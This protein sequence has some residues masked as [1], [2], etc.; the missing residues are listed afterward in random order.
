MARWADLEREAPEVA[1]PGR[2]L[3]YQHG[4]G[5]AYLATNRKDGGL[6]I[7]PFC[8][9]V[10]NGGIYGLVGRSPKR[11]DLART[12]RF[13]IHAFPKAESDDEFMLAGEAVR[14]VTGEA[15]LKIVSDAYHATGST[16]S[17]DEDTYEFVIGRALFAL[18][19]ARDGK[20]TWPPQYFKWRAR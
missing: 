2:A 17:G 10:T 15:E 14:L 1:G 8:P 3:L 16:S 9:V 4:P 11:D 18:Y 7:H 12:G 13:A 6:R 20:P 5:L 19:R